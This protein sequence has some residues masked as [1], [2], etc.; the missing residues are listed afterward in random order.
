MNNNYKM[1]AIASNYR[2]NHR[3]FKSNSI[4]S[5]W[6]VFM[7]NHNRSYVFGRLSVFSTHADQDDA[8]WAFM[9]Y[10]MERGVN[11]SY[12]NFGF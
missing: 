8:L 4:R 7:N 11:N 1:A 5:P 6:G 10:S 9:S 2:N 12:L 3:I